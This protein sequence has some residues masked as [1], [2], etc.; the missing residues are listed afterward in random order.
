MDSLEFYLFYGDPTQ[1]MDIL[2]KHP[3][4]GRLKMEALSA[5]NKF[6]PCDGSLFFTVDGRGSTHSYSL[7]NIQGNDLHRYLD[8]YQWHDPMHPRRFLDAQRCLVQLDDVEP[9]RCD[10]RSIFFREFLTVLNLHHEVN[11]FLRDN[12]GLVA[13]IALTR[14]RSRGHFTSQEL[15]YLGWLAPVLES[16]LRVVLGRTQRSP[17]TLSKVFDLTERESEVVELIRSGASNAD[18]ARRL[19]ISRSTVKTHL[20]HIFGKV[21]VNSRTRLLYSLENVGLC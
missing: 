3:A 11:I 1:L 12:V 16:S 17:A 15:S 21:G 2:E 9:A 18:V 20:A 10:Q 14:N 19:Q 6:V 13:G 5:L 4:I 7:L 8:R